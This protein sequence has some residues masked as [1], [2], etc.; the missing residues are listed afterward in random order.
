MGNGFLR[1]DGVRIMEKISKQTRNITKQGILIINQADLMVSLKHPDGTV[2]LNVTDETNFHRQDYK[3]NKRNEVESTLQFE[4][5][6]KKNDKSFSGTFLIRT[7]TSNMD[8]LEAN[9]EGLVE[10][11]KAGG[12]PLASPASSSGDTPLASPVID[13]EGYRTGTVE[14]L[15]KSD[16]KPTETTGDEAK[17]DEVVFLGTTA[18]NQ[19]VSVGDRLFGA[20]LVMNHSVVYFSFVILPCRKM[21]TNPDPFTVTK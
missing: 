12:T 5:D 16:T 19:T 7:L 14:A 9:L 11:L 18:G 17:E 1:V 8:D 6:I 13:K 15:E 2:I 10:R 3:P 4:G 20:V 21:T